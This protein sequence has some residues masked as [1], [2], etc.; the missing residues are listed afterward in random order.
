MFN[1]NKKIQ[2]KKQNKNREF[3]K[4]LS[5]KFT[6]ID[7]TRF[8]TS[9]LSNLVDNLAHGIHKIKCK[10]RHNNKKQEKCEINCKYC[11]CCI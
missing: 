3:T 10:Y 5:Y 8:M 1:F 9:S 2:L 11:K 7:G 6:F 4:T